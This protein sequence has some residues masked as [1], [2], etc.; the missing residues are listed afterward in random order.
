MKFLQFPMSQYIPYTYIKSHSSCNF[1][2]GRTVGKSPYAAP[3]SESEATKARHDGEIAHLRHST[4]GK[5]QKKCCQALAAIFSAKLN[6]QYV[7]SKQ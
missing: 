1:G 6:A 4:R 2:D 5:M 3:V 7:Q